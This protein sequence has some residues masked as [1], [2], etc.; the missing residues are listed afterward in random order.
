MAFGPSWEVAETQGVLATDL[1][2]THSSGAR[3]PCIS[4]GK[5][6]A[7]NAGEPGSVSG[8]RRSPGGG[9]G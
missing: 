3:I 7:C 2:D 6:S 5:E 1:N 4:D 9:N 8:S